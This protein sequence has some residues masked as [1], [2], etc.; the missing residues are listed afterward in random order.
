MDS[1]GTS[2]HDN[3]NLPLHPGINYSK[4]DVGGDIGG[5]VFAIGSVVVTLIGVPALRSFLFASLGAG[6]AFAFA[7]HAWFQHHPPRR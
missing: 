5:A 1:S 4:T 7:L 6:I 2:S 3:R